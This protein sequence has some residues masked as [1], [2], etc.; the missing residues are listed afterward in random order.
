MKFPTCGHPDLLQGGPSVK[1]RH[2]ALTLGLCALLA[3]CQT[4]DQ[5]HVESNKDLQH[6]VPVDRL[7]IQLETQDL[8][9]LVSSPPVDTTSNPETKPNAVPSNSTGNALV[10]L[11]ELVKQEVEKQFDELHIPIE[12]IYLTGLELDSS[13]AEDAKAKFGADYTLVMK[14]AGESVDVKHG[15]Y[16]SKVGNTSYYTPTTTTTTTYLFDA[17]VS[18]EVNQKTIWRSRLSIT[19]QIEESTIRELV[20]DTIQ[21]LAGDQLLD[22]KGQAQPPVDL[23]KKLSPFGIVLLVIALNL[24]LFIMLQL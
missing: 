18:D 20:H 15:G 3:S 5:V 8:K 2:V 9:V 1:S 10:T 13:S 11:G 14:K 24:P 16:T 12:C 17:S 7:F 6:R 22:L 19:G 21:Q 4:V 23:P